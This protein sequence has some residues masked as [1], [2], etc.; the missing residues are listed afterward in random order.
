MRLGKTET[1]KQCVVVP[2]LFLTV[3]SIHKEE[4]LQASKCFAVIIPKCLVFM[5]NAIYCRGYFTNFTTKACHNS[6]F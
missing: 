5:K 4:S 6:T 2:C 3:G 1:H